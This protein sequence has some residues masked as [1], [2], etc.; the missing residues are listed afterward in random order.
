MYNN[1]PKGRKIHTYFLIKVNIRCNIG[2]KYR[3]IHFA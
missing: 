2:P 3:I 1:G